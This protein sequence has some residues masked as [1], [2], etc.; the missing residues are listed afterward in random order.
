M[1]DFLGALAGLFSLKGFR[2]VYCGRDVPSGSVCSGCGLQEEVLRNKKGFYGNLLYVFGYDGIVRRLIHNFK[3]NDMPYVGGYMAEKM[4]ACLQEMQIQFDLIT[5]VPVHENRLKWRGFDQAEMLASY[6]SAQTGVPYKKLLLRARDTPPQFDL[7]R[8]ERKINVKGAFRA[9]EP[10]HLAG[11]KV[12]L[13]D[14]VCTT[15]STLRECARILEKAGAVVI[16]FA[17]AREN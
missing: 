10:L 2:C 13:I 11:K 6:L 5:F 7:G 3:Y 17:Y 16:P 4:Y 8:E 9:A 12:I 1:A 15:G 14:D